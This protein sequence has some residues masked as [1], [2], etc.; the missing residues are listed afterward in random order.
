MTTMSVGRVEGVLR[1]RP[2]CEKSKHTT[3]KG[4]TC[5]GEGCAVDD[6]TDDADSDGYDFMSST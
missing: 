2:H 1:R 6:A 3:V 4:S 5:N